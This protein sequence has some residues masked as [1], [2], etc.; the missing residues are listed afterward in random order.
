[1]LSPACSVNHR[2]PSG[3]AV[4][5][6]GCESAVAKGVK[7]YGATGTVVVVV[8]VPRPVGGGPT[9]VVGDI[10][11]ITAGAAGPPRVAGWYGAAGRPDAGSE[12]LAR[13]SGIDDV[14]PADSAGDRLRATGPGPPSAGA[15]LTAGHSGAD[16]GGPAVLDV[17]GRAAVDDVVPTTVNLVWADPFEWKIQA[18]RTTLPRTIAVATAGNLL[19]ASRSPA[20]LR[21]RASPRSSTRVESRSAT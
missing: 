8:E 15:G 6:D 16:D 2:L 7:T 5:P 18:D 1:M 14:G 19:R 4:M 21:C 13:D 20:T 10:P 11:P 12:P 3:P 17:V 9:P